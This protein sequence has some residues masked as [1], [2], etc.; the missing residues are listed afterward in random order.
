M[1][2]KGRFTARTPLHVG[3]YGESVETDLPLARNGAGAWYIPGT[4][5]TGVL[6]AWCLSAFGEEATDVLWGP[7]MTRGNPDRGHA[8][9]VL[10]ED[11]EVTLP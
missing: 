10:I 3:G 8:S 1:R 9:F 5:I 11:A 6:R 2:I 7:P 4:S